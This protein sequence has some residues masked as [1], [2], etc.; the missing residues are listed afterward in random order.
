[1][2]NIGDLDQ[3]PVAS[4]LGLDCLSMSIFCGGGGGERRGWG[5]P[6]IN[7]LKVTPKKTDLFIL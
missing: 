4:D 3:M 7:G 1:M 5:A 6:C 2:A